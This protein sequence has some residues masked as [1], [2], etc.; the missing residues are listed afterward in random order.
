[1]RGA[2][3]RAGRSSSAARCRGWKTARCCTGQGRFAADINLSRP[4]AHA[5]G[6][7]ARR[8]WQDQHRSMRRRR[9]RC[10]ACTRCGRFADVAHIPPI[11]FRLTGLERA[12]ALSPARAGAASIVRYVG[13]PVAAVFADD[14]Y[15]AEDAAD[16]VELDIEPLPPVTRRRR[17]RRRRSTTGALPK[18]TIIAKGY[19][20]VDAAFRAAHAIVALDLSIGRHSGVPLETR[21]AIAR[22]DER[23]TCW[24]CTA[25][26]RCRTGTATASR[27]CSAARPRACSSTKAMSAA[28]SAS[29]ARSIRRTCWSAPPRSQFKR[30]IKWIEDRREHLIA[31][32]H[33]RQQHHQ[34]PGGDRQRRPHPR[35]RR[36]IL[37]RQ[38]RLYAHACR[39]GARSRRRHAARPLSRAGLSRASAT[40]ASPTRRRAA[41]I[42]RPAA[43]KRPSCASG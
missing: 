13:E 5:R 25:P 38:R 9:W 6:A 8:A 41:P 1:M 23:A 29:A 37:P 21:G 17:P 18:P 30:P 39:D 33:S 32:N 15:I 34:H 3:D 35:H 4:M 19:G 27:R 20:D 40:S 2:N 7:L 36:R 10:P 43:T 26:P 24:K 11:G 22:Y 16:L 42:A 28:A 12:R 14:A 31:A